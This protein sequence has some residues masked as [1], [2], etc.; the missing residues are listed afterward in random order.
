MPLADLLAVF[1]FPQ[2]G[3]GAQ[4]ANHHDAVKVGGACEWK[5]L[6][7]VGTTSDYSLTDL[8]SQYGHLSIVVS[9]Q[10]NPGRQWRN[11]VGILCCCAVPC[12]AYSRLLGSTCDYQM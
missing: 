10:A 7:S 2:G 1:C 6:A 8:L 11:R 4:L 5:S 9:G 12:Y 3:G